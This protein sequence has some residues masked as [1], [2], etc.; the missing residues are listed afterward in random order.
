MQDIWC[1]GHRFSLKTILG[2]FS[3][4]L[5]SVFA[6]VLTQKGMFYTVIKTCQVYDLYID[7]SHIFNTEKTCLKGPLKN[8]QN[9]D[10]ND[11]W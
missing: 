5:H 6:N 7:H 8:R 4:L 3:V 2:N 9:K 11:K 10:L 1:G